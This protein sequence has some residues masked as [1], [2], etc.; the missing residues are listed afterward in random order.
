M[1]IT[2]P[3][4]NIDFIIS[5]QKKNMLVPFVPKK[6]TFV[7]KILLLSHN[8]KFKVEIHSSFEM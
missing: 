7:H 5:S 3:V 4:F 2:Y 8:L 6:K 1:L